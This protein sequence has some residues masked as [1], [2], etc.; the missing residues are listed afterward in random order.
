[1]THGTSGGAGGFI[2]EAHGMNSSAS[3]STAPP[4]TTGSFFPSRDQCRTLIL[5]C[6]NATFG[7]DMQRDGWTGRIVNVDYSSVV[8]EQMRAKYGAAFYHENAM[9]NHVSVMEWLQADITQPLPFE[10]GSFDLIVC[11]GSFDAILCGAGSRSSIG[12]VVQE[13]V[14]LLA[15][16]T[17]VFFLVTH[18]NGNPDYRIEYLEHENDLYHFWS[19]VQVHTVLRQPPPQQ[20]HHYHHHHRLLGMPHPS[21]GVL[22]HSR[23]VHCHE[24]IN[25]AIALD[26]SRCSLTPSPLM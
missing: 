23:Y 13:C 11:K 6:G 21:H 2:L 22:P 17:G 14:R 16:G 8:I 1:M 25:G 18:G 24:V 5:G 10:K 12:R 20:Q 26:P 15:P 7:E 3:T 19:S 9:P 4:I